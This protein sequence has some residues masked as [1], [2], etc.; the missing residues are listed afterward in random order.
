[1]VSAVINGFDELSGNYR[2]TLDTRP[3]YDVLPLAVELAAAGIADAGLAQ[4]IQQAIK[5]ALG[6]TARIE[7]LPSGSFELSEGKTRRVLRSYQ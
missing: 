1:M 4:A 5:Q 7:L 6:A 2:I 3:P